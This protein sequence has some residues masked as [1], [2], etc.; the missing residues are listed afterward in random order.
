MAYHAR[1]SPS[2]ADGW[3]ACADWASDPT[4][5]KYAR[6]GTA[7]HDVAHMAG[8]DGK[9]AAA[10]HGRIID[11]DG[12]AIQVDDEMVEIAQA[13]LDTA[14]P[15]ET[16][17]EQ[18]LPI[19]HLTG[20]DGA[21]GTADRV[22]IADTEMVVDDLKTGRGVRVDAEQNKQLTLYAQAAVDQF[23]VLYDFTHVRMRIVQPP[24]NHVSEWVLPVEALAEFVLAITPATEVVPGE[25]QCRWCAK[26]A[27]CKALQA[28]VAADL[29]S[30]Q[31]PAD[32][33]D[34]RIATLLGRLDLIEDWCKSIRAEAERR[35]FAGHDL[36]GYKLVEGKKG[37]RAW[38]DETLVETVLKSMRLR[39][40]EMYQFKLMSPTQLEKSLKDQ[41]KRWARLEQHITQKSGGPAVV[42]ATDKRP[43]ISVAVDPSEFT[44]ITETA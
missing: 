26:K 34:A 33:D 24:L 37:S 29:E 38:A 6:K 14:V 22:T 11:V 7:T 23:A 8:T 41:P 5:S 42:P 35:L 21:T 43:A 18:C 16:F 20:E 1:F 30:A 44:P 12:E 19:G 31:P 27:N 39:Q 13:F 3:S 28:S 2:G 25:K 15:G 36:P 4:G 9:P 17:L 10:Y 40:D 32:A